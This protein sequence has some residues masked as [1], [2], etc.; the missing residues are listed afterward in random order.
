VNAG[1]P[2]CTTCL[3]LFTI[4]KAGHARPPPL[5]KIAKICGYPWPEAR[6][7]EYP[8]PS[9]RIQRKVAAMGQAIKPGQKRHLDFLTGLRLCEAV[10]RDFPE[11]TRWKVIRILAIVLDEMQRSVDERRC[12]MKRFDQLDARDRVLLM[13]RLI[14]KFA[15]SGYLDRCNGSIAEWA[16]TAGLDAFAIWREV[17]TDVGFDE[18]VP[19]PA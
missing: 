5:W 1:K 2:Q 9:S 3:A 7:A 18:C 17:C 16:R 10:E 13:T 8:G 14:T 12:V 15:D 19:W 4:E 6:L 11:L